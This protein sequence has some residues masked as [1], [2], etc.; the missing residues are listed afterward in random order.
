MCT[1]HL[2][3]DLMSKKEQK[4]F[5]HSH[6]RAGR[7]GRILRDDP[8]QLPPLQMGKLKPRDPAACP[9]QKQQVSGCPLLQSA[10]H[11]SPFIKALPSVCFEVTTRPSAGRENKSITSSMMKLQQ[12]AYICIML[13]V[14]SPKAFSHS[15]WALLLK[16]NTFG[17]RKRR[18]PTPV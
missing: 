9:W 18:R 7:P 16:I 11:P 13:S 2:R 17:G 4:H 14:F 10:C 5:I 12:E 15:L 6:F 8:V 3:N 1:K